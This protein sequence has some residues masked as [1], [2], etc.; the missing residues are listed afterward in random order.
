MKTHRIVLVVA[1]VALM[2]APATPAFAVSK[3]I[4]QLQTQVQ[5]LQDQMARMQQSFDERMG[6]MRN[7]VEQNTDGMNRIVAAM[8]ELQKTL[9]QQ[10]M[11][12]SGR[13]EQVS[14]QI[15]TLNDSIDELKGRMAKI[16]TQIDQLAAQQQ[17]LPAQPA[18]TGAVAPMQSQAPPPEVLYNNALRDYNSGKYDL[19]SGEF[20]DFLRYY[21]THDLAGNAQFYAADIEYR[22][23]NF[24]QAV[25]GYDKVLEQYP[26]GNKSSAAQLKKGLALIQLGEKQ[27][28]TK[29]LQ[30]LIQRYP[31]SIEATTARDQLRKL[32]AS[33]S[34]KP[35]AARRRP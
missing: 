6:I 18:P 21:P 9:N 28:G 5:A 15:Q 20:G 7:L 8:G 32:G 1:M 12:V 19:A 22:A 11:D 10:Q 25:V 29:E 26:G 4:I 35:S 23:G 30:S 14:G 16:S 3:E 24:E 34:A 27:A 31:R 33:G 2:I 13:S 17:N